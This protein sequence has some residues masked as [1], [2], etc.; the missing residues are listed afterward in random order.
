MFLDTHDVEA[1]QRTEIDNDFDVILDASGTRAVLRDMSLPSKSAEKEKGTPHTLYVLL[2]DILNTC[3]WSHPVITDVDVDAEA[4]E[5][6]KNEEEVEDAPPQLLIGRKKQSRKKN[7]TFGVT[8][9]FERVKGDHRKE[10]ILGK[11]FYLFQAEFKA[12]TVRL[13]N[14]VYFRSVLSNCMWMDMCVVR[15]AGMLLVG[16]TWWRL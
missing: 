16:Q 9:N 10:Q 8:A 12:K 15:R 5:E 7:D 6:S 13:E 14:V 4:N 2:E 3:I 1:P 11:A